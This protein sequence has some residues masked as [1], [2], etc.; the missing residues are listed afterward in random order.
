MKNIFSSLI[1]F[2]KTGYIGFAMGLPILI[3]IVVDII[4]FFVYYRIYN[5]NIPHNIS[6]QGLACF[7][8]FAGLSG[9]IQ[10]IR[11]ESPGFTFDKPFRGTMPII[12]G[13]I[14]ILIFWSSTLVML[15][16]SVINR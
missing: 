9:I 12:S 14:I 7:G 2:M 11:R 16:F 4:W 1:N 5:G 3:G 13:L 6:A 10:I 15:Y 8:F